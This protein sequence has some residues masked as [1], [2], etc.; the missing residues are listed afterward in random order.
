MMATALSS[1]YFLTL[2]EKRDLL[3]Y[4][5]DE[6]NSLMNDYWIPSGLVPMSSSSISDEDLEETMKRLRIE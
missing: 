2:N 6:T 4:S 3:G 1:I 5:A